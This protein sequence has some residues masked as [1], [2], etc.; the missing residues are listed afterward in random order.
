M[1]DFS[2]KGYFTPKIYCSANSL[3]I[4]SC[5]ADA[6]VST[7]NLEDLGVKLPLSCLKQVQHKSD[8]EKHSLEHSLEFGA[9]PSESQQ[10]RLVVPQS[11]PRALRKK[12]T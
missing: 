6:Y 4:Y 1:P 9:K 10:T 7:F 2:Q 5:Q 3:L 11:G 12:Q 8:L